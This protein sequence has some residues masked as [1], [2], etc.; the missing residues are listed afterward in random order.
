VTLNAGTLI[1]VRLVDGLS[2][3]RNAPG[4]VFTASMDRPLVVDGFII[5]ERGA[6]VDGRVV[7]SD[8]GGRVKGVA[9]LAVEITRIHTADGQ[10]I[11]V[12]TDSFERRAEQSQKQDAA[13]VGVGAAIGAAIGAIAGG[14]KGAAIGGPYLFG[15][16][17]DWT[18]DT[19]WSLVFVALVMVVGAVATLFGRETRGAK[20]A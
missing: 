19:V 4:D 15:A 13:K 12:Q 9:G 11:A 7:S 2:S 17:I 6:R 14:G 18:G 3:E 8:R 20:L 10:T 1:P 5:A 16:L